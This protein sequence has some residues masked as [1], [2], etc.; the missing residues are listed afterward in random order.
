MESNNLIFVDI[1]CNDINIL[2]PVIDRFKKL[3][4][5]AIE[6]QK[7]EDRD[8]VNFITIQSIELTPNIIFELGYYYAGWI[9]QLRDS[10]KID[11]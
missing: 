6:I 5:I 10:K 4:G 1:V 9:Q 2:I 8:G 11:W 3:Y 7:E